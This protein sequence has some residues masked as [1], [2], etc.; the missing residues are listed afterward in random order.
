MSPI[1]RRILQVAV[2]LV[3]L[4]ALLSS[5]ALAAKTITVALWSIGKPIVS[6][7]LIQ[8]FEEANPGIKVQLLEVPSGQVYDEWIKVQ[9]AGGSPPDIFAIGDWNVQEYADLDLITPLDL[10]A[11]GYTSLQQVRR[12]FLPGALDAFILDQ[13]LYGLPQ[14]WNTLLLYYNKTIFGEV[15]LPLP[16]FH[17]FSSTDFLTAARKVQQIDADGKVKRAAVTS[18]WSH[19]LLATFEFNAHVR[20]FGGSLFGPNGEETIDSPAVRAA[21]NYLF[22]LVHDKQ[23]GSN[24]HSFVH[25]TS[26]MRFS[27]PWEAAGYTQIDFDLVPW[28]SGETTVVPAYAWIWV[29]SKGSPNVIEASQFMRFCLV[30]NSDY[31][32]TYASFIHPRADFARYTLYKQQPPL[33]N[34]LKAAEMAKYAEPAP[35][36]NEYSAAIQ[37]L[38]WSAVGPN[39]LPDYQAI[40][41][42]ARQVRAILE[43]AGRK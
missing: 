10:R 32:G 8:R 7:E 41:D 31:F 37:K 34:F 2:V 11:A 9:M 36:Y 15:G 28:T 5:T 19:G 35:I 17:S 1:S 6:P 18:A 29:L 27:G 40:A 43:K 12:D 30:D 20:S 23:F 21:Y 13:Y 39:P 22:D 3:A 4:G 42:A 26:A 33:L 16:D 14:E 38:V 24:S 25:G